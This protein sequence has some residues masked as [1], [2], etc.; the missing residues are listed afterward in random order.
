MKQPVE[1]IRLSA[2]ARDR[3]LQTKKVTGMQH[4]NELC[5]WAFCLALESEEDFPQD[6]H[7]DRNSIEMNWT[8]FAGD[9]DRPMTAIVWLK[10]RQFIKKHP[11]T[12]ISTYV[13][14]ALEHGIAMLPRAL[15]N[16]QGKYLCA[17]PL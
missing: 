9:F 15:Q 14:L 2:G 4:W 10:W 6:L 12:T 17:L 3:L 5:R 11:N 7:P 16:T 13:H 8:T 1:T